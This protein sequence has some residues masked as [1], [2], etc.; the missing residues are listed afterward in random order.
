MT[1][2][3]FPHS[4]ISGSKCVCHSPELFA[5]YHVLHRLLVPRHPPCALSSLTEFRCSLGAYPSHLLRLSKTRRGARAPRSFSSGV[6]R[7]SENRLESPV[8]HCR[9]SACCGSRGIE[10][11]SRISLPVWWR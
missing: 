1:P 7:E 11:V 6:P 8:V 3:G 9:S 5:A 2:A 10:D 4:D